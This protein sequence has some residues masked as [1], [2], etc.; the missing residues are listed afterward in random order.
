MTSGKRE[1]TGGGYGSVVRHATWWTIHIPD[2]SI[3]HTTACS[4]CATTVTSGMCTVRTAEKMMTAPFTSLSLIWRRTRVAQGKPGVVTP[5]VKKLPIFPFEQSSNSS[6]H[7][8]SWDLFKL[9]DFVMNL[10]KRFCEELHVTFIRLLWIAY[11]THT[12]THTHT[13]EFAQTTKVLGRDRNY[14]WYQL[15]VHF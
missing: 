13:P 14:G 1:D 15:S 5:S 11:T 7:V 9:S 4:W 2:G 10:F 12:H 6:W 8:P 3:S